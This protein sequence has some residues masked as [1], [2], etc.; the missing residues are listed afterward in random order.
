MRT[1]DATMT[2]SPPVP[3]RLAAVALLAALASGALHLGCDSDS[4]AVKEPTPGV[5][6]GTTPTIDG[7]PNPIDGGRDP[8]DGGP[9]DCV[10]NPK[11]HA[12]IINGCTDAVK[13]TKNPTLPL[14]SPDG[15]LP[16][17]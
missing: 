4:T 10:Q 3:L 2:T 16:P 12:E 11:T 14:L 15:G 13:I 9:T 7:G 1:K 8:V 5:D 17:L 6:S